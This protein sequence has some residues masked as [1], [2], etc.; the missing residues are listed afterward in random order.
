MTLVITALGCGGAEGILAA[1]ASF[2]SGKGHIVSL[3]VLNPGEVFVSLPSEVKP[4][5]L[6]GEA[7]ARSGWLPRLL[8]LVRKQRR[9]RQAIADESPDVVISFID[10]ANVWTLLSTIGMACPVIVSERVYPPAYRLATVYR[11]ARRLLYA[12]AKAVVL[13][14]EAAADWAR[15]W[16]AA[17]R[18]TVLPNPVQPV[19]RPRAPAAELELAAGYRLVAVGRL[20]HQK[21][22]DLLINA[23][24]E[25][26]PRFPEWS[27]VILGE[28]EQRSALERLAAARGI[29][30]RVH[31][32]GA[33]KRPEL[34]LQRCHLYVLSSRFEG[35]PNALCEAMA[36][37][38]PVVSFACPAGPQEI[39]REGID[40]YLVPAGDVPALVTALRRLLENRAERQRLGGRAREIVQRFPAEAILNRWEALCCKVAGLGR[41]AQ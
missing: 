26:C 19:S 9:L 18:V 35:F 31:L 24:A 11:M 37:G 28:G 39:I 22:F 27:L 15:R 16:L 38:L 1:L 32:R 23:F 21:G 13:Q 5:F 36:C 17:D 6:A 33:V 2:L 12:R 29:A 30:D 8:T 4:R 25:L 20:V 3:L 40:G 10:V 34:V 41:G 14:T 7:Q